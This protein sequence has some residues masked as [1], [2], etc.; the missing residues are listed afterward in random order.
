MLKKILTFT[1]AMTAFIFGM[2][3]LKSRKSKTSR[4]TTLEVNNP[5]AESDKNISDSIDRALDDLEN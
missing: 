4:K 5:D 1:S 3:F 2:W